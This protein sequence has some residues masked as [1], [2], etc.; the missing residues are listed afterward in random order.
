MVFDRSYAPV[1]SA[2]VQS[3]FHKQRVLA[4][5]RFGAGS[6]VQIPPSFSL[7]DAFTADVKLINRRQR[8]YVPS[9]CAFGSYR[10]AVAGFFVPRLS[11]S[12]SIRWCRNQRH[13]G[14][15]ILAFRRFIQRV[16]LIL[17]VET[18]S[19]DKS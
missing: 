5:G 7:S 2:S 3:I 6:P 18:V 13:Y 17:T 8:R 11:R 16:D 4:G 12:I 14:Q 10:A 1:V 15:M 9:V 19:S